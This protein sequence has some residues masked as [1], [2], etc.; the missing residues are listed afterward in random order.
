LAFTFCFGVETVSSGLPMRQPCGH[1]RASGASFSSPTLQPFSS[2]ASRS[3]LSRAL[4]LRS[5]CHWPTFGSAVQ[6]GMTS[7]FTTRLIV[8]A[9]DFT[10]S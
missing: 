9:W 5:L 7:F 2:H 10:S 8:A 6:G 4:R 3:A 1:W